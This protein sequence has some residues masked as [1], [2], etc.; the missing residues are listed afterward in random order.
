VAF[1]KNFRAKALAGLKF[2]EHKPLNFPAIF[3]I[4]KEI[5][6]KC[7]E[8]GRWDSVAFV[9]KRELKMTKSLDQ[10]K[11]RPFASVFRT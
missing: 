2:K 7:L 9:R 11:N 10:L 8:P 3:H 6:V 5:P 4:A 1:F